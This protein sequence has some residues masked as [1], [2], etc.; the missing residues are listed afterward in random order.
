MAMVFQNF[1]LRAS[2]HV[3]PIE[4]VDS[5]LDQVKHFCSSDENFSQLEVSSTKKNGRIILSFVFKA[6]GLDEAEAFAEKSL[7]RI[8][9]ELNRGNEKNTADEKIKEGSNLL[10]F[11]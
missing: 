7:S 9:A 6:E 8:S 4:V 5:V 11:A 1:A 3:N 10:T 2:L